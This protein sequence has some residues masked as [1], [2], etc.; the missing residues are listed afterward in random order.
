[1]R[2]LHFKFIRP[3]GSDK[4]FVILALL[5]VLIPQKTH[6]HSY[7]EDSDTAVVLHVSPDDDPIIGEPANLLYEFRGSFDVIKCVCKIVVSKEEKEYEVVYSPLSSHLARG[8]VTF[9]EKGIYHL[10]LSGS[11]ESGDQFSLK[12]DLRVEREVG[13]KAKLSP[14]IFHLLL[15]I[16]GVGVVLYSLWERFIKKRGHDARN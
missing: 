6:A 13:Q 11:N 3:P 2:G 4:F 16:A 8:E 12:Y 9:P 15:A 14:H 1:M 5:L 7:I 10:T